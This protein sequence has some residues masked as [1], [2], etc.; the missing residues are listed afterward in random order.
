MQIRKFSH[1]L[2]AV[3]VLTAAACS[4][5][6]DASTATLV[7]QTDPDLSGNVIKVEYE[8]GNGPGFGPYSQWDIWVLVPPAS[9]ANAGVVLPVAAPVF[10]RRNGGLATATA[11]QIR[12]GDR[13]QVWRDPVHVSFGAVQGPPGAPTYEG[14]QIVI[15]R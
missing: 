1:A 5:A 15:V 14:T 10:L 7:L 6:T 2:I 12:V 13:V 4:S 11:S 9:S 8:S 3:S